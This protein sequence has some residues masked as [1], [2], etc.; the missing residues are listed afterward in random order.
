MHVRWL[1]SA[2]SCTL[3][4]VALLSCGG[5]YDAGTGLYHDDGNG[6]FIQFPAGWYEGS[7][8]AG[9]VVTVVAPDDSAQMNMVVQELPQSVTFDQYV[10]QL[11]SR[12]GSAGARKVEE[13]EM[14]MGGVGGFW[15]VRSLSVGG[16]R[17]MAVNYS[18]MNGYRVYSLI[19]IVGEADFPTYRPVFENAAE[20]LMFTS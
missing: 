13:G 5:N 19:G 10:E 16:Q 6:F 7:T 12:W 14:I 8:P 3:M 15:T 4:C 18:V 20:S 17:F 9:V 11:V 1:C 2:A